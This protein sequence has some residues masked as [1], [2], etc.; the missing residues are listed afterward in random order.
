MAG[1]AWS[2]G[3]PPQIHGRPQMG[4]NRVKRN[5]KPGSSAV[6]PH[7]W[8]QLTTGGGFEAFKMVEK[9][10][11]DSFSRGYSAEKTPL[12]AKRRLLGGAGIV[13]DGGEF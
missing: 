11:C 4:P 6:V 9:T 5:S 13:A 1:G 7:H 2:E 8:I 10:E 12:D 3:D